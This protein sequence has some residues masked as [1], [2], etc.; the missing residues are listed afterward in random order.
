M[1]VGEALFMYGQDLV[2]RGRGI[3]S[4]TKTLRYLPS[5]VSHR[6]YLL[7]LPN[8]AF[9]NCHYVAL[10]EYFLKFYQSRISFLFFFKLSKAFEVF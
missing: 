10:R 6:H 3:N 1:G 9:I 4:W 7:L 8:S 5:A 2:Y